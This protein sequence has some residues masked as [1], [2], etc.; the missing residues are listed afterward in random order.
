T[1]VTVTAD[2][3]VVVPL[4]SGPRMIRVASDELI[5]SAED[6]MP[7]VISALAGE[8]AVM[9]LGLANPAPANAGNLVVDGVA[10]RARGSAKTETALGDLAGE[11]LAYLEGAPWGTSGPLSRS[12]TTAVITPY[13][14]LEL[15]PGA[16]G[17]LEIRMILVENPAAA[18]ISLGLALDDISARQ[19]EGELVAVRILPAPGQV[20]P[21]WTEAGTLT[22]ATLEESYSNFPNPFAAGRERTAFVFVLGGGAT[23]DLRLYTPR[24][25]LVRTLLDGAALAAGLHQ[26]VTWDGRNGRGDVVRNGVYVAELS[27]GGDDGTSTLLRR[28]VAVVR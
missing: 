18:S 12:D 11:I 10:L 5:V 9:R 21:F 28:K 4:S 14:V 3:G 15:G 27:V 6:L 25:E 13:E 19:P 26:D 24:G 16:A 2:A 22:A 17:T 1:P 23:V 20:F 8:T 7:A